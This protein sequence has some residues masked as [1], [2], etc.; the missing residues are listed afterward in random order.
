MSLVHSSPAPAKSPGAHFKRGGFRSQRQ[1]GGGFMLLEWLLSL[2][3]GGLL[4]AAVCMLYYFTSRSFVA[5]TN[6][7]DLN[8]SSRQAL[9]YMTRDIRQ[10]NYLISATTNQLVFSSGTGTNSFTWNPTTGVLTRGMTGEPDKVL[11]TGC[12]YLKFNTYQRNMSNQVFG[13]F[14]N[15]TPTTC[16]LVDLSWRCSRA[17]LRQAVNTESVQTAKIVIRNEHL[18]GF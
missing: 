3:I 15:S 16:K 8:I 11:L 13:A 17:I 14:S 4:I 18:A 1:H 10:A 9:D 2:G 5:A 12:D 7:T 6:Y